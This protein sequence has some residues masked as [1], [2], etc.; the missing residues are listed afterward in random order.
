MACA[1]PVLGGRSFVVGGLAAQRKTL[2]APGEGP[3]WFD[4]RCAFRRYLRLSPGSHREPVIRARSP[5]RRSSS[6]PRMDTSTPLDS[7]TGTCR[8]SARIAMTEK[9]RF[10]FGR[11]HLAKGLLPRRR[12]C[13]LYT[14]SR[15]PVQRATRSSS[16]S[17][18]V[19]GR[20]VV[21]RCGP[22]ATSSAPPGVASAPAA[23]RRRPAPAGVTRPR[24]RRRS[25]DASLGPQSA[26]TPGGSAGADGRPPSAD[27]ARTA[28]NRHDASIARAA[29]HARSSSI[30]RT[31]RRAEARR[32]THPRLSAVADEA[33]AM[34]HEPAAKAR[35]RLQA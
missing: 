27:S 33:Q 34:S 31:P 19:R 30:G 12:R 17:A 11:A 29:A 9:R 14:L 23:E 8:P 16:A 21:V 13:G 5:S 20:A 24:A 35:A 26:A 3:G 10:R 22:R 1:L 18:M 7:V 15:T 25:G 6:L 4:V 28:P 2:A 32:R